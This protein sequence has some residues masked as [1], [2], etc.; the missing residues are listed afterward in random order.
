MEGKMYIDTHTK[1]SMEESVCEYLGVKKRDLEELFKKIDSLKK[2]H[3]AEEENE[4]IMDFIYSHPIKKAINEILF[5]HLSRRL[6]NDKEFRGDNLYDALTKDTSLSRFLK[7]YDIVFK[8]KEN[9][10]ELFHCGEIQNIS[11]LDNEMTGYIE[12][13]MG[14]YED[15]DDYC[16]NGYAFK[17]LA[18]SNGY[19][20][21]LEEGA[22]FLVRL[23]RALNRE[24][25]IEEYKK[26]STYYYIEYKIPI[27]K[28]LFDENEDFSLEDKRIQIVLKSL[29]RL[30]DYHK[31]GS[32]CV[33]DNGNP[34]LRLKDDD[35]MEEKC[36]IAAEKL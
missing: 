29:Q 35:I 36:F 30:Y 31:Y 7:K 16:L 3:K 10:L 17:D 18:K 22:E 34:V 26:N 20:A 2:P 8:K 1:E 13:R 5:F 32:D 27:Q 28:V 4:I 24:D 21:S 11:D 14:L 15:E 12:S 9:H 25:I 19:K 6:N 23:L 33:R